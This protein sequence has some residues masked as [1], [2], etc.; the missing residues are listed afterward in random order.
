M[1]R[2]LEVEMSRRISAEEALKHKF[3]DD[4]D[5]ETLNKL[6]NYEWV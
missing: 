1:R 3:F 4:I 6:I 5:K 2:L